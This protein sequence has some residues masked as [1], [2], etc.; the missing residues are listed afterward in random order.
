[1]H[2]RQ[3]NVLLELLSLSFIKINVV[4][5]D[6][7]HYRKPVMYMYSSF[8]PNLPPVRFEDVNL[9]KYLS[10]VNTSVQ[11][12]TRVAVVVCCCDAEVG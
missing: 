12:L 5:V 11:Y 8:T 9:A 3:V 2:C 7:L 4:L 6:D 10:V 1:M